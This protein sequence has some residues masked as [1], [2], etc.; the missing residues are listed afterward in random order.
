M[1]FGVGYDGE[2]GDGH[3]G[4]LG[5]E[6]SGTGKYGSEGGGGHQGS[7]GKDE[8]MDICHM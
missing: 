8:G 7:V 4:K 5:S 6:P 3:N 2:H 1:N